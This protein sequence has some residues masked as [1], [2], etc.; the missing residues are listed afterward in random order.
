MTLQTFLA[1]LAFA[2]SRPLLYKSE[3]GIIV[4]NLTEGRMG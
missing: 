3:I 1:F 2:G 4:Q